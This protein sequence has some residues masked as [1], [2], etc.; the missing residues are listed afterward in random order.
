MG[1]LLAKQTKVQGEMEKKE[2]LDKLKKFRKGKLKNLDFLE[3]A[4]QLE[5]KK[6]QSA[7]K[8]KQRN[9][10]FGFVGKRKAQNEILKIHRRVSKKFVASRKAH[11]KE[12]AIDQGRQDVRKQNI[13]NNFF[14]LKRLINKYI[15]IKLK[16]K[17]FLNTFWVALFYFVRFC[18]R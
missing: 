8:R 15:K 9:K 1:K 18:T 4:R 5:S 16:R 11:K 14:S 17:M 12:S 3:D 10:K 2:M 13:R 7:E 6:K